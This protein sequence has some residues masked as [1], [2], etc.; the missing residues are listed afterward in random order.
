M[1]RHFLVLSLC[2]ASLVSA[3]PV[4]LNVGTA[5]PRESPWGKVLRAWVKGVTDKTKGEVTIVL[6]WNAT[7]GDEAA[8]MA[9]VKTGQLDG[10]VV[11][12]VGLG[13]IDPDVNI[14]QV[15]G[16]YK[17]W[18]QL[19]KVRD[20]LKPRFEKSFRA[21]GIELV[22]WGDV[23]LDRFMSKGYGVKTPA[24]LK[25]KRAWVWRDDP[26][27]PPLFQVTQTVMVPTGLAEVIPELSTGNVT[28]LSV[29]ALAAEQMQWASK[30]DHFTRSVVAPNI[31]GMVLSKAKLDALSPASREAVLET[32]RLAAKALTD[33]IRGEDAKALL[34][35]EKRM[36]V[37]ELSP[38]D[39]KDWDV[40][41]A[42]A[43]ARLGKGTFSP[44]LLAEVEQ[45]AK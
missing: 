15:P 24:D 2:V 25:G 26:V 12:A 20:I 39:V 44:K 37:V 1:L 40:V 7:Q 21:A 28:L 41:F 34:R 6:F 16:V 11:T 19:D 9:K 8:Q 4:T 17:D 5:V 23:G 35:L 27:L 3:E 38:E 22:G 30:L 43:R 10:A 18:A 29:S 31:G 32:G 45:L 13:V 42:E 33:T 14:L 36:T